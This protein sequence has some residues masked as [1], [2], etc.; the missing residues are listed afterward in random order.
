VNRNNKVKTWA[1]LLKDPRVQETWTENNDGVDYWV[2]LKSPWKTCDGVG[3]IHE[4]SKA[5]CIRELN[6]SVN[7]A[8]TREAESDARAELLAQERD[9]LEAQGL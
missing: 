8:A 2:V 1:G 7:L 5:D 3:S 4:W 6:A 9:N